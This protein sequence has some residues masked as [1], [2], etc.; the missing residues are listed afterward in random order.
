MF[1]LCCSPVSPG[2]QGYK[3]V[4]VLSQTGSTAHFQALAGSHGLDTCVTQSHSLSLFW[5]GNFSPDVGLLKCGDGRRR[6]TNTDADTKVWKGSATCV[7]KKR[8]KKKAPRGN[9]ERDM[10][11]HREHCHMTFSQ[12]G[13]TWLEEPCWRACCHITVFLNYCLSCPSSRNV[14]K[15]P[16]HVRS[17]RSKQVYPSSN[18]HSSLLN[19]NNWTFGVSHA[20]QFCPKVTKQPAGN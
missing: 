5:C 20:Q 11:S 13:D 10:L 16:L 1:V 2:G 9:K 12:V 3:N 19:N 17:P 15:H 18:L 4:S 8:G 14:F 6:G 7:G